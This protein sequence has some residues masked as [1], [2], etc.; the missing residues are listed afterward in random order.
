[1]I[2]I[3]KEF[4][5]H[6]E[7]SNK[8]LLSTEENYKKL[9]A[10]NDVNKKTIENLTNTNNELTA[11][12]KNILSNSNNNNDRLLNNIKNKTLLDTSNIKNS[13]TNQNISLLNPNMSITEIEKQIVSIEYLKN[14]LLKYLDAMAIGNEFQTKVLENVIFAVLN[15]PNQE[16]V[17][18]EEKRSR[19]YFYYNLWYNAKAFVSARIYG[20][21][22][23]PQTIPN[24][25]I[26]PNMK[27]APFDASVNNI[28]N[29]GFKI[30]E[31]IHHENKEKM[32]RLSSEDL[33]MIDRKDLNDIY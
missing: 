14:V 33:D 30:N 11:Q 24:L 7:R 31:P 27:N 8:I 32:R 4:H 17:K 18:L 19:S 10:E 12:N 26:D 13:L 3:K 23:H 6:R 9:M 28:L 25:S 2:T 1:L 29:P 22:T 15:I 21:G 5:E 20:N 16:K